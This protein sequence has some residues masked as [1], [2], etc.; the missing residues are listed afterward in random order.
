MERQ[1]DLYLISDDK[2]L[3]Q[4]ERIY[5]MLHSTYWAKERTRETIARASTQGHE[6]EMADRAEAAARDSQA[7]EYAEAARARDAA[8]ALRAEKLRTP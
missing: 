3:L 4:I 2:K 7:A 8:S 1:F 5:E 6:R